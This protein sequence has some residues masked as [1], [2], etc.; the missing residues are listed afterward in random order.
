VASEIRRIACTMATKSISPGALMLA[1]VIGASASTGDAS[2]PAFGIALASAT[3]QVTV[4]TAEPLPAGATVSIQYLDAHSSVRCCRTLAAEDFEPGPGHEGAVDRD[5]AGL[6]L[7]HVFKH[8]IPSHHPEPFAGIAAVHLP[9][10]RVRQVSTRVLRGPGRATRAARACFSA[11]G[12]HV[13]TFERGRRLSDLYLGLGYSV[14]TPD[15]K[16]GPGRT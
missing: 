1:W 10:T 4:Y 14:E 9:G 16:E 8:Q 12:F 13:R 11:E 15:C 2:K 7:Q 6:L 5:S 3:G